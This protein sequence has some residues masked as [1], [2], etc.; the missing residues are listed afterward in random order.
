MKCDSLWKDSYISNLK[1]CLIKVWSKWNDVSAFC[2]HRWAGLGEGIHRIVAT[3]IDFLTPKVWLW[4]TMQEEKNKY[5]LNENHRLGSEELG[6]IA[7]GGRVKG[8]RRSPTSRIRIRGWEIW[9]DGTTREKP[10]FHTIVIPQKGEST[11]AICCESW[12]VR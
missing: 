5:R 8:S 3:H 6:R 10:D 1:V 12:T 9:R 11:T 2:S 4:A 7:S